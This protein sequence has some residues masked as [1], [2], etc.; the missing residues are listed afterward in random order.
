MA[1]LGR[2]HP[3]FAVA[4]ADLLVT[5]VQLSAF[6]ILQVGLQS[7][8]FDGTVSR[9]VWA[10]RVGLAVAMRAELVQFSIKHFM[11]G[12]MAGQKGRI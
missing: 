9:Y 10:H 6:D 5:R 2:L 3:V 4:F 8:A 7:A 1:A 11:A 12:R